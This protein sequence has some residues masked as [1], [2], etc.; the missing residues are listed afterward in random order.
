MSYDDVAVIS[1]I[2]IG[3]VVN[4][5]GIADEAADAVAVAVFNKIDGD[6]DDAGDKD[7]EDVDDDVKDDALNDE[8]SLV[9]KL[10]KFVNV[11]NCFQGHGDPEEVVD[12]LSIPSLPIPNCF[13]L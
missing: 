12:I 3:F 6:E 7:N 11:V 4:L 2:W 1:L 10:F 8:G 13:L 9:V 5:E